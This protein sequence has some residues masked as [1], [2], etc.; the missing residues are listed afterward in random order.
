MT[1]HD[2]SVI[3]LMNEKCHHN[4]NYVGANY[5]GTIQYNNQSSETE[6]L[7][8]IIQLKDEILAQKENELEVLR[9]LVSILEKNQK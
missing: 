8:L 2:K 3:F 7:N 5:Q 1:I 4:K 9:K 6:K